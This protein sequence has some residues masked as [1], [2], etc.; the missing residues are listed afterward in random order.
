MEDFELIRKNEADPYYFNP[1]LKFEEHI[2]DGFLSICKAPPPF[3]FV[4]SQARN[5]QSVGAVTTERFPAL[6]N[7]RFFGNKKTPGVSDSQVFC[8]IEPQEL[9]FTFERDTSKAKH[10]RSRALLLKDKRARY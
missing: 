2:V 3:S 9:P 5:K 8:S 4:A 1:C 10:K 7:E 6:T